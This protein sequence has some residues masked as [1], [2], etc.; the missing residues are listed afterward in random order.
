MDIRRNPRNAEIQ[1]FRVAWTRRDLEYNYECT[2]IA[3][4]DC[5]CVCYN[6]DAMALLCTG[7]FVASPKERYH[8]ILE[9]CFMVS[10]VS[11]GIVAQ[12]WREEVF[13]WNPGGR[14]ELRGIWFSNS[15]IEDVGTWFVV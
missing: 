2:C 1:R 10:V 15:K 13:Q 5:N 7:L 8:T 14:T 3:L 6:K 12:R 9:V 11:I 4:C